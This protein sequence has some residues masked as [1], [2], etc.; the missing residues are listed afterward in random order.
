MDLKE[1]SESVQQ[2]SAPVPLISP[3]RQIRSRFQ[4][5]LD[6]TI[7]SCK[8][9]LGINEISEDV[10]TAVE[11]SDSEDSEKSE[12]SDSEY[13]SDEEQKPKNEPEDPEDKEGNR[14]DKEA[15][16]IKRKPKPSNQVEVKEEVKSNSPI[17]EKVDPAPAKDK[18][19]P[20]PEKDFAEKAKPSPHPAKDKLKGKDETDSPTVHLGLDS[21]SESEL[22]IDLGEDPSGREGR[23]SKKEPKVPSPKQDAIGKPPPSTPAGNQSPPETPV[24]T[25][26]AT[27]APAAGVTVAATTSTMSTVTVTAPATATV[28]GSPVK[29]QRPLLPKE[30]VPAV[31]RVVWNASTVQQKEVTQ[32]PSTSTITL[33]TS[34]QPA[35]LV[36]SS[37]SA[38]TL[39]SAINADLPIATASADVAADIAKYTS[40]MMDAIKGTMTEIYNDLSKNTTGSTI[41]EIRRLRI[42]IEKLQWLH[43]QELAEMK[44]N[45]ELTMAEMR[46][47]L[48]Q[49][50]DRLIAEVKK[51]LE[52]EKQQA[53]DETKKKQWCANCKK[54]AIFYCC[55]NTSYCDYPCQQAHWP[56]HMKSCTQS[57]TA[58]Q[59]EA[60]AEANQETGNKTSQG[61][62]S[63]T[64]SAPSE[65]ASTPKEKETSSSS[66][67]SSSTEKNK[68][69]NSTLDLSGSRETPS[70]ILLGSNQGSVSKRCDKQPAYT[71]TTTDHQPHPNYPAQKYHSRSS[72]AGLWSSNEEK[73][74]SS[75]SEHSAGTSTKNVMPKES[76]ESRLDTFWD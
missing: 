46:Q 3:K 45:L 20:E 34:T 28:T 37:G 19:S 47:S 67:S 59:Q 23:K 72:K 43:Q 53:V 16:A 27:Q 31:Q 22:V 75:R 48:E 65:P 61:S 30:T 44:H 26:S 58:P 7:E 13:V 73:R 76:R 52:L 11:H 15:T 40:K 9:Q 74:G 36:S 49:E 24:L 5:N 25:R 17:G 1:L 57:A 35:A 4:L 32:S 41:A 38:S 12:S 6:K 50:R 71:P 70:S 14:V 68:D 55:W 60:D 51:Q 63:N 18:A 69:S 64:Q 33:V 56:E 42:E 8:A 62:S 66:S 21:D 39:A 10:Y 2:Q 29:K 54:E